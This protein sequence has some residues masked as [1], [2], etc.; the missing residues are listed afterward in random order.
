MESGLIWIGSS[1]SQ[2]AGFHTLGSSRWALPA[3]RGAGKRRFLVGSSVTKGPVRV[4]GWA[5][6]RAIKLASRISRVPCQSP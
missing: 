5:P 1:E 3:Y 2:Y 4:K 6:L